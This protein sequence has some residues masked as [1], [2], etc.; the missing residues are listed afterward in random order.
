MTESITSI[1][2]VFKKAHFPNADFIKKA[3]NS[4][5]RQQVP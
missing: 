3:Q 4:P 2:P 5:R 1:F